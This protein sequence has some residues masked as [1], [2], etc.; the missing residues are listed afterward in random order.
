MSALWIYTLEQLCMIDV[1]ELEKDDYNNLLAQI[2]NY[3][4]PSLMDQYLK[5]MKND[6]KV[7]Y[8]DFLEKNELLDLINS[9]FEPRIQ[10]DKYILK[11][12]INSLNKND[13]LS[14]SKLLLNDNSLEVIDITNLKKELLTDKY[15]KEI[16]YNIQK[17]IA[18]ILVDS[19]LAMER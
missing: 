13:L 2:G 5:L 7:E 14:L 17:R 9:R 11:I 4:F 15:L 10:L 18:K 16:I 6:F 19:K 1:E 12:I 8:H 3:K